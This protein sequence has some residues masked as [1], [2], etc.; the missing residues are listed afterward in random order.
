M[1]TE[2][3]DLA[4]EYD[5][6][7]EEASGEHPT[8]EPVEGGDEPEEELEEEPVEDGD[9]PEEPAEEPTEE[10]VEDGDEPVEGGD[11]PTE[12]PTEPVEEP[13]EPPQA[14]EPQ[15]PKFDAETLRRAQELMQQRQQQQ[16][17]QPAE[18]E[19]P[20]APKTWRD[21]IPEDKRGIID[22]YEQEW[23]EVAEAEQ[24]IREAQLQLVKQEVYSELGRAL[25]PVFETTQ[26]LKVNAHLDAIRQVH[27]DL[28]DIRGELTDWIETQPEFVRP[29]YQEVA[30][31]G[32]AQQ[33]IE[34][35]NQ[36]KQ[37]TGKTG[38]VPAVPASSAR[39]QQPAA[40]APRQPP[41]AAKKAMAA[42]PASRKAE[43]PG[44]ARPEDFDAAWEEATGL[45]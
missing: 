11:E 38:A 33:V 4:N 13:T 44:S 39:T 26:T 40:K 28:D 12:E 19:T 6:A 24:L 21:M 20:E 31:K 37:S 43:V 23:G 42:A 2:A 32:S 36:F 16:Q 18:E 27:S 10:P 7:F 41:A 17:Q 1:G 30:Q 35:I 22:K 45:G 3:Q 29:A 9:E 15:A 34:L 25:A 14:Q 5:D 8:E